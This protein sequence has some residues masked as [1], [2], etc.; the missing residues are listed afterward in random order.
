MIEFRKGSEVL[1]NGTFKEREISKNI[2]A[3]ERALGEEKLL[4]VLNFSSKNRTVDYRG[5]VVF[6]NT[7]RRIF[8]GTMFPYEAVILKEGKATE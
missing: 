2:F 3:Y 8:N 6:S 4:V 7:E 5:E 1:I